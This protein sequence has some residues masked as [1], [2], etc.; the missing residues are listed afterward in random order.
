LRQRVRFRSKKSLVPQRQ[1]QNTFSAS[2]HE[3]KRWIE[4]SGL[5]RKKWRRTREFFDI[6]PEARDPPLFTADIFSRIL[7]RA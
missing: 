1:P 5:D 3:N 6:A 7:R 2:I 4:L